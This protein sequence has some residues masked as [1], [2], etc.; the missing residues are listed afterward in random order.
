M[1]RKGDLSHPLGSTSASSPSAGALRLGPQYALGRGRGRGEGATHSSN[2]QNYFYTL[3]DRYDSDNVV[4]NLLTISSQDI[5]ALIDPT[6]TFSY[7]T[8]FIDSKS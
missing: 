8:P 4:T 7:V 6:S 5:Y 2:N 3:I 1:L